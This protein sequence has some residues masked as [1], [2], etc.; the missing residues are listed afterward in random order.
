LL[1]PNVPGLLQERGNDEESKIMAKNLGLLAVPLTAALLLLN[2]ISAQERKVTVTGWGGTYQDATRD[3][4]MKPYEKATGVKVLEDSW[5]GESGKIKAMVDSGTANWDV[6]FANISDAIAGCEQGYLE[7]IDPALLKEIKDFVP[8]TAHKC[9]IPLN[10]WALVTAY[11]GA[12]IP[13][14]WGDKRP[15]KLEDFFDTVNFPGPRG[16]RRNPMMTIEFALMADGVPASKVY[17]VMSTPAGIDRAL[18]KL[19]AVKSSIVYWTT[20]AQPL[21]L[22]ADGE[23]V[24]SMIHNGRVYSANKDGK[25]LVPIWDREIVGTETLIVVKNKNTKESM[26]LIKFMMDPKLMGDFTKYYPY[27][28]SRSSGAPFVS[29]TTADYLPTQGDRM[30][31]S[32]RRDDEWWEDNRDKVLLKWNV[33]LAK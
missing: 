14:S 4:F 9:G 7:P 31:D 18:R 10:V 26:N 28:P 24:M 2:G 19:D 23:V 11:N 16:V 8:G 17:E 32:L 21:Q 13:K 6:V 29:P 22:L 15:T 1:W 27:G 25:K 33:W 12:N 5:N 20:N 3:V 30:K